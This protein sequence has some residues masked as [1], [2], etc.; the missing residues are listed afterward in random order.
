[1]AAFTMRPTPSASSRLASL[2]LLFVTACG[3][4]TVGLSP[5]AAPS[6]VAADVAADAAPPP[7]GTAD[8]GVDALS[9]PLPESAADCARDDECEMVARGCYC[10]QQ[11]VEGVN[12]R[13]AAAAGACQDLARRSCAL[14]CAVFPGRSTQ[15]G[16]NDADGG[17]IAVRCERDAGAGRCWTYLR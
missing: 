8:T 1:V 11:P 17:T 4:T 3:S 13:F 9:C 2:S 10:G 15:S 14:G 12:R 16:Q 7:D 5:D 6:D